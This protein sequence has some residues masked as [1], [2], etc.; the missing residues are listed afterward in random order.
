MKTKKTKPNVRVVAK[1]IKDLSE[2][3]VKELKRKCYHPD[4]GIMNQNLVRAR[5]AKA[6]KSQVVMAKQVGTGKVL[7]WALIDKDVDERQ[8]Q[9]EVCY[10]T[11]TRFRRLGL[12]TKVAKK[13]EK[14]LDT[15][16]YDHYPEQNPIF[17]AKIGAKR[18]NFRGKPY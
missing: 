11:C 17:F 15:N 9:P 16:V 6:S 7:S 12:G 3:R 2:K 5:E 14:I 13:V 8:K 10:W 18:Y 4:T 1:S